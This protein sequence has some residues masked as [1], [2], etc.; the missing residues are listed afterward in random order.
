MGMKK[1]N[2][3]NS[4]EV[5]LGAALLISTPALRANGTGHCSLESY[6]AQAGL[7][8]ANEGD[9]LAVTWEGGKG[10]ELRMQLQ[11]ENGTPTI[12]DLSVRKSGGQWA[13]L[14]KNLTP[15]YRVVTGRR[16]LDQEAY[17]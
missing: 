1:W 4:F 7:A 9:G 6:K 5:A 15:E 8:A 11:I 2:A 13:S 17:P 3:K 16:R 12:E 14:G 10:Q